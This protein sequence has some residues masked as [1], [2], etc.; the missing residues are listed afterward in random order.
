M[1][2]GP[3][4][5]MNLTDVAERIETIIAEAQHINQRLEQAGDTLRGGG[6]DTN[7]QGAN[8]PQPS[9]LIPLIG[10][11][12]G[13]LES[14]QSEQRQ[15]MNRIQDG[16]SEAPPPTQLGAEQNAK[17]MQARRY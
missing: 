5:E 10:Y 1:E 2:T 4:R 3:A 14:I 9:G 7:A 11:R 17:V 6:R 12:L 13:V 8:A 15:A 16:L